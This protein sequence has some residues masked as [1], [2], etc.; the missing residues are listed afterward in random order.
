LLDLGVGES[1]DADHH[2]VNPVSEY[3]WS[4]AAQR[5]VASQL[6]HYVGLGVEQRVD[7]GADFRRALASRIAGMGDQRTDDVNVVLG[8]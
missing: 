5:R 8:L 3:R 4:K 6:D 1:T 7:V 2:Q